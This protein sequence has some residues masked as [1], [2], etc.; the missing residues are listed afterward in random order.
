MSREIL[1]A[2]K[3]RSAHQQ[4]VALAT[5]L[6]L[7]AFALGGR[8]QCLHLTVTLQSSRAFWRLPLLIVV[9]CCTLAFITALL[10]FLLEMSAAKCSGLLRG[11]CQ[12]GLLQPCSH[13]SPPCWSQI[14][15][16][17]DWGKSGLWG[18]G[19]RK[20]VQIS[21]FG[22]LACVMAGANA[23]PRQLCKLH[24]AVCAVSGRAPL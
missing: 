6:L 5:A 24:T 13:R 18:K 3:R 17:A 23:V 22:H 15:N 1:D 21:V 2:G 8:L 16:R 9:L 7:L 4:P 14:L 11:G 20:L 12:S 10:T 19:N